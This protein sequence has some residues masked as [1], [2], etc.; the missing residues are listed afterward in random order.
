MA[1]STCCTMAR[2]TVLSPRRSSAAVRSAANSTPSMPDGVS[3]RL[4]NA[5][6]SAIWPQRDT[7]GPSIPLSTLRTNN[8]A[9]LPSED[10]V[11]PR[12]SGP[13][14][15]TSSVERRAAGGM[16]KLGRRPSNSSISSVSAESS[17]S[18]S[19]IRRR[20][21]RARSIPLVG[22]EADGVAFA[23]DAPRE[24]EPDDLVLSGM[25]CTTGRDVVA[26]AGAGVGAG[27]GAGAGL[28]AGAGDGRGAGAGAGSSNPGGSSD[29][30]A[31]CA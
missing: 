5:R 13:S 23:D 14:R 21:S 7:S 2:A 27:R 9:V 1:V 8:P 26:G 3:S 11:I 28:G 18:S 30:G 17:V 24:P 22:A 19:L 29:S 4:A 20:I 6:R 10:A 25:S 15:P 12:S 16:S 31:P